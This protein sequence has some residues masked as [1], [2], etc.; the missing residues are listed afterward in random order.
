MRKLRKSFGICATSSPSSVIPKRICSA[1]AMRRGN[2]GASAGPRSHSAQE[3]RGEMPLRQ[4]E[5][6]TESFHSFQGLKVFLSMLKPMASCL[7]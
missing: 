2:S 1:S 5:I 3:L 7:A 6:S 4:R